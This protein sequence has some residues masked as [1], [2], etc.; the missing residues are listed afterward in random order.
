M[1]SVYLLLLKTVLP[2]LIVAILTLPANSA[3]QMK[4]PEPYQVAEAYEI[5]SAILPTRWPVTEAHAKTLL[6]RAE[7]GSGPDMCLKPEGESVSIV[8]P[9]IADF[10]EV[11]KKPWLLQK[12]FQINQPYEFIFDKELDG[13]FSDG[14]HG[15][16][17][18]NEKY[19]D[20]GGYNEF[21]AVGFNADKT[22]AVVYAAHSCGGLCGGG[23]FYVLAKKEGKWQELKWK[24]SSCSWMS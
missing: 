11:N 6:I 20:S 22:V 23:E 2:S 24:G 10:I 3:A 9:A 21:S 1:R 8:G 12:A 13:I 19:P 14:V 17:S 16:K 18:F 4:Q 15:W 5:Y 7:T